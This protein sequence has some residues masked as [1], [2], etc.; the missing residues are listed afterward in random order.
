[1]LGLSRLALLNQAPWAARRLCSG[2]LAYPSDS[3]RRACG[4]AV[5]PEGLRTHALLAVRLGCG[6]RSSDVLNLDLGQYTAKHFACV[7]VKGGYMRDVVP[8]QRDASEVPD[9]RQKQRGDSP[10]P[11]FPT[12]TNR[13]LCRC[14]AA[15]IIGRI[16]GRANA[17]R[18]RQGHMQVTL[19]VLR[20]TFLRKPAE[21]KGVHDV[22]EASGHQS[23]R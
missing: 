4:P 20:H 5:G 12:R 18:P 1:M 14:E 9:A 7:Q 13:R 3:R 19:H 2:P 22:R 10:G 15:A 23:D 8:V 6:L 21:A 17:N 16:A 11:L